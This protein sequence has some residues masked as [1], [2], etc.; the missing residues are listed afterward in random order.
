[1]NGQQA[2]TIAQ[3]EILAYGKAN[4]QRPDPDDPMIL[5]P[6]NHASMDRE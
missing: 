3:R 5:I 2:T 6:G 1:M 4:R